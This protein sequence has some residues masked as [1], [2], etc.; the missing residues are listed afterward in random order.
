MVPVV[1]GHLM[2]GLGDSRLT[3]GIIQMT[4]EE[5]NVRFVLNRPLSPVY[6]DGFRQV[7][8][9]TGILP[10]DSSFSLPSSSS[11][12]SAA[13]PFV[14]PPLLDLPGAFGF[15]LPQFDSS[16][17]VG[18]PHNPFG[19]GRPSFGGGGGSGTPGEPGS[20]G[21]SQVVIIEWLPINTPLPF[22][23]FE[24]S[25]SPVEIV[26]P[27]ISNVEVNFAE[28]QMTKTSTTFRLGFRAHKIVRVPNP[29]MPLETETV[30]QLTPLVTIDAPTTQQIAA[31]RS[32]V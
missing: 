24:V 14:L 2:P 6:G 7:R 12:A 16:P 27:Y 32:C 29:L 28:S 17:P 10:R 13:L 20:P 25:L 1:G 11:S 19:P 31:L 8:E 18:S 30:V 5:N 15:F 26:H 23:A 22:G 4:A 9:A 21:T 3:P